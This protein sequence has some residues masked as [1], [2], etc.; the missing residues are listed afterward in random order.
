MVL[1]LLVVAPNLIAIFGMHW[2]S[3]S[4][5][6]ICF[7]SQTEPHSFC[8]I[9]LRHSVQQITYCSWPKPCPCLCCSDACLPCFECMQVSYQHCC[10]RYGNACSAVVMAT[11]H[12]M[13]QSFAM[14]G[15]F[16]T[17]ACST[18]APAVA[19]TVMRVVPLWWL[20]RKAWCRALWWLVR[21]C[22]A[23]QNKPLPASLK[24]ATL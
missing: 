2:Q 3:C 23:G 13:V 22:P 24:A 14:A 17:Q 21:W 6:Y 12:G 9:S 15:D 20:Q 10:C 18:A 16:K 11:A 1:L 19:G 8:S 4:Y 7:M 5:L